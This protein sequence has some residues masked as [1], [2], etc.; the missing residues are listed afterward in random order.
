MR[1]SR[2]DVSER[3][4]IAT[5]AALALPEVKARQRAGLKSAWADPAKRDAHNSPV[6]NAWKR[7]QRFYSNFLKP[8]A[9]RLLLASPAQRAG[10]EMINS[11]DRAVRH[12]L[13]RRRAERS[14]TQVSAVRKM[15]NQ[16]RAYVHPTWIGTNDRWQPF[17]SNDDDR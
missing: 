13:G 2:P 10:A 5:T 12:P 4:S 17:P 3:I 6:P 15:W 16:G 8:T 14:A 11:R 1:M 7:P 9:K